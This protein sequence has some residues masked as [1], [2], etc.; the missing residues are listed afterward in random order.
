MSTDDRGH[1]LPA[2]LVVDHDP[3]V[4]EPIVE[5]LAADGYPVRLARTAE[6]ARALARA[7][8]PEV[9]LIG[10]LECPRAG[11]ELLVEIRGGDRTKPNGDLPQRGGEPAKP[12]SD[13]TKPSGEPKPR[14]DLTKLSGEPTVVPGEVLAWPGDLPAIVMSSRVEEPNVLRAFE[15][16]ADDF[17]PSPPS[18][19]EL[20][21]RLRALLSRA[22]GD[23]RPQAVHVGALEVDVRAHT[24]SLHGQPLQL[25]RLEY[26]LLLHLARDPERVCSKQ[27]LMRVVWGYHLQGSTRTLD[28]HASR[29]RRAL[30]DAGGEQWVVNVRGVGY[31]LI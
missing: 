1:D 14:S 6:H 30:G 20:R 31:R 16:G 21:A 9:A 10:D 15:A 29:L 27:E 8:L 5:Q 13:P 28:S 22:G 7:S 24:A 18:Y 11:L 26:E 19:L 12:R 25:R 17:I 4:G 2:I 23:R 3:L